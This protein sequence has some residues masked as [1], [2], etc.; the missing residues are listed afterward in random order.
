MS[1]ISLSIARKRGL[2]VVPTTKHR[3]L[4]ADDKELDVAGST[5]FIIGGVTIEALVTPSIKDDLLLGWQD[6][7]RLQVISEDFPSAPC[8]ET[9]LKLD[10]T[11]PEGDCQLLETQIKLEFADVLHD[12]MPDTHMKGPPMRIE[13]RDDVKV[14]PKKVTTTKQTPT[15]L[16]ADAAKDIAM[17]LEN[18]VIERVPVDE[19][20]DWISPAFFV[21]KPKGG[22]RL[23]TDFTK[24]NLYTKRP[25]HPFPCAT[26]IARAIPATAKY[27]CKLDAI[28]GY[29]QIPLDKDSRKL[30][31]F[32]LPNGKFRY[33]RG[34]MGLRSTNDCWCQRSDEAVAGLPGVAKI[35]DD[36]LIWAPTLSILKERIRK[37]LNRCRT[38]GIAISRP[39]L[40][41]ATELNFAG[42]IVSSAGIIPDS[43]KLAAIRDFPPPKDVSGVRSFLGMVN[44]LGHYL[45]DL[46]K[47]TGNIRTL[48]KKDVAYQ[49]LPEHQKD[50]EELKKTLTDKMMLHFFD[51]T[52]ETSLLTDAASKFGIGY[53]LVQRSAEGDLRLIQAGSRSLTSAELNYAPIE[54]EC[55]AAVW[56]I[57]KCKHYL[58]GMPLFHVVTDHQPLVGL[59]LKDLGVIEN[60]RLQRLREKVIDYSFEV[61]WVAGKTHHIADAL[62]R[63]PVDTVAAHDH[64]L[65]TILHAADP[66]LTPLLEAAKED[67]V[68]S[69]LVQA[70]HT[71]TKAQVKSLLPTDPLRQFLSFWDELSIYENEE[72]RLVTYQ[73][74]RI[75]VPSTQRRRLLELLHRG[76][77]GVVKM[78]QYA[79]Q[80]Y[81]W[82]GISNDIAQFVANCE[83][84]FELLPSQPNLPLTQTVAAAPME[85]VSTD[86][87]SHG[88]REFLTLVDRYSGMIWCHRLSRS[89][90]D[91]VTSI[92]RGIFN[93]Y[94]YPTK[95]RSDGGPQFRGPFDLWCSEHGVAH[96]TTSPYN[97]QSNGHA[98]AA[99]K[100]AKYLLKKCDANL[101]HFEDALAAWCRTPRADGLSPADLFFGRRLR[102][103]LP[104]IQP[105][106]VS[107]TDLS[108]SLSKRALDREAAKARLDARSRP[109]PPCLPGQPVVLQNPHT[110]EWTDGGEVVKQRS[111]DGQSYDV[112]TDQNKR[113]SRNRKFIRLKESADQPRT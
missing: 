57:S 37:V 20:T 64:S 21:P 98:E 86:L 18:G 54:V 10:K 112:L 85:Q 91:A 52:L 58:Y 101:R 24:L 110:K 46:S 40:R 28:Q 30:T 23:V 45:P 71:K 88:G 2:E 51:P 67:E 15:H 103:L 90:T 70:V 76:H 108:H 78:R 92:L 75:V 77:P 68:Y 36:I 62:S 26:D 97:P 66:L 41:I 94:G 16:Q 55:L 6:L 33:A 93:N 73:A 35:V 69:R 72:G 43:K 104:S 8:V 1:I 99:V 87:F 96:E 63:H 102:S 50:F 11:L 111:A 34:P 80:M 9:V 60:R 113:T 13:L 44:Q 7:R 4:S 74:H 27:F 47:M 56:A 106:P 81:F 32:L 84:C 29:H 100:Q 17:F 89:N 42:F 107:S 105:S 38:S 3:L 109:L 39:K 31:T 95:I 49:W 14:I 53:A 5:K 82:P 25:V 59:F 48:L 65:N 83:K 12:S 61:K 22:V 19:V 79:K